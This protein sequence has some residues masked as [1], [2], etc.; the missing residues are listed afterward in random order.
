M[1]I[2]PID[3]WHDYGTIRVSSR[4][5]PSDPRPSPTKSNNISVEARSVDEDTD[6]EIHM[7]YH[8]VRLL[9]SY[10]VYLGSL[11]VLAWLRAC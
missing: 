11:F 10:L 5:L 7:D 3:E 1:S 6:E 4:G 9:P 8:F 2:L